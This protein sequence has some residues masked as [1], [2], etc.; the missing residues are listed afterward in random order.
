MTEISIEIVSNF[1]PRIINLLESIRKQTFQEY[2]IIVGTNSEELI[3]LVK[4]FDTKIAYKENAGV[5]Y[6][7]MIAH[8]LSR[9]RKSL[10]LEATRYLTSD[11]LF[12]L[13]SIS[14]D[15]VIIEE[16]DIGDNFIAKV[17]NI[18]RSANVHKISTFS[19]DSLIVEPR[20]FSKYVLDVA[21]REI[22]AIPLPILTNMQY[23]DLDI[24]YYEAFKISQDIYAT[25]TPLIYHYTDENIFGFI[26]K[27]YNYGK[28]NRYIKM[29]QYK[30]K[31]TLSKAGM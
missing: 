23:G 17:Q 10:L 5:L 19:P 6:R 12:K 16:K 15:L 13:S 29:T 2:E 1:D 27:Y 4:N 7:R 26:K 20:M 9:S 25:N 30:K 22:E 28:S 18:E 31:F 8:K 24:I 14:H 3:D 21:F 11:S